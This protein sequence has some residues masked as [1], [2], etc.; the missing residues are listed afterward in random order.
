MILNLV[1]IFP[2][3]FSIKYTQY[4]KLCCWY[5]V[6]TK[7][8]YYNSHVSNVLCIH[9]L[10]FIKHKYIRS[11]CLLTWTATI[12]DNIIIIII[13][14]KWIRKC[15]PLIDDI[16]IKTQNYFVIAKR[17]AFYSRK[18]AVHAFATPNERYLGN[19]IYAIL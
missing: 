19:E 4:V 17:K 9:V 2:D 11:S 7:S 14:D 18:L 1:S 15:P 10:N 5:S 12:N 3:K 6:F 13:I 16:E 8:Q